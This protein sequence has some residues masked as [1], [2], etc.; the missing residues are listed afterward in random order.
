MCIEQPNTY[1]SKIHSLWIRMHGSSMGNQEIRLLFERIATLWDLDGSQATSWNILKGSKRFRQSKT[2]EIREKIMF[3][4]FSV[5]WVPWK[6]HYIA[7]ALSHAPVF[8][9]AELEE[10]QR[11]I[12]DTIPCLRISN[13]PTLDII[14][15]ATKD[16]AYT[17]AAA[18]LLQTGKHATPGKSSPLH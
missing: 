8:S 18:E 17:K 15:E 10:D 13:N 5:E 9:A 2:H 6:T 14:T 11:D 16:N 7:D 1:T 3:Y 12:E 4:N